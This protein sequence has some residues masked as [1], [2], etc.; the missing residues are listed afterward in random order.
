MQL[1]RLSVL[2]VLLKYFASDITLQLLAEAIIVARTS[3]DKVTLQH[4]IR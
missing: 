2:E 4:C 3:G 1:V